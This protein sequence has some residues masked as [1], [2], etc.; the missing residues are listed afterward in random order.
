MT[1][2]DKMVT[3]AHHILGNINQDEFNKFQILDECLNAFVTKIKE[4]DVLIEELQT[5]LITK[6]EK[7]DPLLI[8][9]KEKIAEVA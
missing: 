1:N 7:E 2:T 3:Y 4:Q 5:K 6:Q 8:I 9:Q